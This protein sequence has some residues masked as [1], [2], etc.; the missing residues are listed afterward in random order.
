MSNSLSLAPPPELARSLPSAHAHSSE[1]SHQR[2]YCGSACGPPRVALQTSKKSTRSA[3]FARVGRQTAF[4]RSSSPS[5]A[6]DLPFER[7]DVPSHSFAGLVRPTVEPALRCRARRSSFICI[8]PGRAA[9]R[10]SGAPADLRS[11]A[12]VRT[13]KGSCLAR[14]RL[15][16]RLVQ[17]EW[18]RVPGPRTVV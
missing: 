10:S 18:V 9:F 13:A 3:L 14:S 4:S 8:V 15:R 2:E 12:R 11:L 5:S 7:V 16:R 6:A 17:C 1:P